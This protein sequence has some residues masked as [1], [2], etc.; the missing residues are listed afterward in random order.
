[1]TFGRTRSRDRSRGNSTRSFV[2]LDLA[3]ALWLRADLGVTLNAG[4]VSAWADQSGNGRS[5]T[6]GTGGAQPVYDATAGANGTAYLELGGTRYLDSASAASAWSFLHTGA[7]T[8]WVVAYKVGVTADITAILSTQATAVH[9]GTLLT[10][11]NTST[12]YRTGQA[13]YRGDGVA[14][15]IAYAT[16]SNNAAPSNTWRALEW[17]FQPASAVIVQSAG[18]VVHLIAGAWT[19]PSGSPTNTAQIGRA[20]TYSFGSATRVAEIIALDRAATAAELARTRA[21]LR[22]RYGVVA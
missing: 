16:S 11:D 22:A 1:M 2:P 8:A 7:L 18:A 9:K 13:I 6:Q 21:Y 17:T 12:L 20:P 19:A 5:F 3:P 10:I 4:N 15:P 14:L